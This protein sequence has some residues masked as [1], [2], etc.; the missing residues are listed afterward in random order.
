M[1]I[2]FL[3]AKLFCVSFVSYVFMEFQ[4]MIKLGN[5]WDLALFDFQFL[6]YSYQSKINDSLFGQELE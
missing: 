2:A 6:K 1:C 5:K 4:D 3:N